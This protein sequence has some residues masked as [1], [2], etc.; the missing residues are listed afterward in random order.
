MFM[1]LLKCPKSRLGSEWHPTPPLPV[2]A[3]GSLIIGDSGC[4]LKLLSAV[5]CE[6]DGLCG[7]HVVA[8]GCEQD[9][10]VHV[11]FVSVCGSAR[12]LTF[13]H[14]RPRPFSY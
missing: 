7:P 9:V 8:L 4:H 5:A 2:I 13:W 12:K 10:A 6:G 14:S 3:A 1:G 11:P